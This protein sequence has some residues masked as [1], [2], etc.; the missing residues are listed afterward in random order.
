[1]D[2]ARMTVDVLCEQISSIEA[3]IGTQVSRLDA[4][5]GTSTEGNATLQTKVAD[6][7]LL[8]DS[9]RESMETREKVVEEW[10]ESFNDRMRAMT[11]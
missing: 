1:M 7:A 6:V 2:N 10:M 4:E 9:Q 5:I 8:L 3:E 11:E